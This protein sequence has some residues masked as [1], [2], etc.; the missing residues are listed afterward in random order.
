MNVPSVSHMGGIWE[1]RIRS[2]T[3]VMSHLLHEQGAQ[4]DDENL[5]TF[6]C[7]ASAILHSRPLSAETINGPLSDP[8]LSPNILLTMK[9]SHSASARKFPEIRR[10]LVNVV[11]VRSI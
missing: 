5:R 7:E 2:I 1:R 10:T 11:G 3:N 8:A 4:L 9:T 6:L